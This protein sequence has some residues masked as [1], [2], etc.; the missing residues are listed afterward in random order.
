MVGCCIRNCAGRAG[1]GGG[2]GRGGDRRHVLADGNLGLGTVGCT[3]RSWPRIAGRFRRY[4]LRFTLAAPETAAG[5]ADSAGR[6]PAVLLRCARRR[7]PGRLQQEGVP[8]RPVPRPSG[9]RG[10]PYR[11]SRVAAELPRRRAAS[12][13]RPQRYVYAE[14][15]LQGRHD[16]GPVARNPDPALWAEPGALAGS[17]PTCAKRSAPSTNGST[18]PGP[19]RRPE[20]GRPVRGPGPG[21]S[22]MRLDAAAPRG[23]CSPVLD[24]PGRDT[25]HA[26]LADL[27]RWAGT[28]LCQHYGGTSCGTAGPVISTPSGTVYLA[29]EWHGTYSGRPPRPGPGLNSTYRWLRR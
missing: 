16:C 13:H 27:R 5:Y 14:L 8:A 4:R 18:R 12:R 11:P 2:P 25:Y 10:P 19:A 6:R 22:P 28:V 24:R 3:V 26:R 17:S 9:L 21:R 15:D 7:R 1:R 23:P 29:A 20:P